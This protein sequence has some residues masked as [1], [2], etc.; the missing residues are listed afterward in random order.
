MRITAM[1]AQC[2][3]HKSTEQSLQFFASIGRFLGLV[4]LSPVACDLWRVVVSR[5]VMV[6]IACPRLRLTVVL[7][8]APGVFDPLSCTR[9]YS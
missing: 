3:T 5:S 4:Y 7:T 8:V 6:P 1:H 2:A 9:S